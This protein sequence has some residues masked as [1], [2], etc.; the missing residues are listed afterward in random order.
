MGDPIFNITLSL[1]IYILSDWVTRFNYK[2]CKARKI[3]KVEKQFGQILR[4]GA[5]Y[6]IFVSKLV[7]RQYIPSWDKIQMTKN[8]VSAESRSDNHLWIKMWRIKENTVWSS[9]LWLN[10]CDHSDFTVTSQHAV[11]LSMYFPVIIE[12]FSTF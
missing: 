3:R 6:N 7:W 4:R 9:F 10:I 11:V 1:I 8:L 2:Q 12:F 5:V